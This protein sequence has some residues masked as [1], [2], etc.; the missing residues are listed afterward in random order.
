MK[1]VLGVGLIIAGIVLGCY[2]GIWVCFVGGLA[3]VI[4]EATS[5]NAI[6]AMNIAEG[7]AK[8]L[9]SGLLGWFSAF[10]LIIPGFTLIYKAWEDY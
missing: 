3:E 1:I 9:F 4:T 7:I 2:V 8:V 10:V 5:P 6:V